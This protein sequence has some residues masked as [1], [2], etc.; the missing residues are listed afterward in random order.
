MS[1]FWQDVRFS[2]R[3]L[4]KSP[5]FTLVAV[6]TMALGVG[7]LSSI[8]SVINAVLFRELPYENPD[9]LV[10]VEGVNL[11]DD[12]QR[13]PFTYPDF[14]ELQRRLTTTEILAARTDSRTFALRTTEGPEMIRG[15]IVSAPYFPLL[16]LKAAVAAR[17]WPRRTG[18]AARGWRSSPTA[19]GTAGTEPTPR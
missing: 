14:I 8:V 3:T 6:L 5:G 9:R 1:S 4:S 19:S 16:G 18:S 7:A 11:K 2:F 15:E 13:L 17:S 10:L 12:T